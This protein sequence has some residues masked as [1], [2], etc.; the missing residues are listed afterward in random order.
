V[1]ID[2]KGS[3]VEDFIRR[4]VLTSSQVTATGSG[5]LG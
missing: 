4:I 3:A 2:T 1:A 5:G